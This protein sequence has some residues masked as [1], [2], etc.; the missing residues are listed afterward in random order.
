M[1]YHVLS[2]EHYDIEKIW[3]LQQNPNLI[4]CWKYKCIVKIQEMIDRSVRS[5]T[6]R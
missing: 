5:C 3:L 4:Y 2:S 6:V 1:N